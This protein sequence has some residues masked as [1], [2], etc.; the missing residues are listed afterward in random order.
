[1]NAFVN[2]GEINTIL[3][4]LAAVIP[5]RL[6]RDLPELT[7]DPASLPRIRE[8]L[9][10]IGAEVAESRKRA[11]VEFPLDDT[12][13]SYLQDHDYQM[14]L[15]GSQRVCFVS[16]YNSYENFLVRT[17]CCAQSID[18]CRTT[19]KDFKKRLVDSFGESIRD[20]CWTAYD[21]NIARLARHA[22]SHAG[23]R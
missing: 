1:H 16:I 7:V 9:V 15:W 20:Q 4:E 14:S 12:W 18:S 10:E 11:K 21:V 19:D 17:L 23:G 8:K 5:G 13:K 6:S 3:L 22:L 2:T